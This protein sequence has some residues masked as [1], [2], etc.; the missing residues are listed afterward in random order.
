MH[1][2][3]FY[4]S[5][6]CFIYLTGLD[7]KIDQKSADSYR[8][9]HYAC[10]NGSCE[11]VTYILTKDSNQANDID[12]LD[13]NMIYLATCSGK[14][15]IVKMILKY[16]NTINQQSIDKCNSI[17]KAI[18]QK[19]FEIFKLLLARKGKSNSKNSSLIIQ[20]LRFGMYNA[21]PLLVENGED[22]DEIIKKEVEGNNKEKRIVYK[23]ALKSACEICDQ[24]KR[25]EIVKYLCSKMKKVD[26]NE[27]IKDS[28][29]VHWIC[30][31]GDPEIVRIVLDK[32]INVNR[33]DEHGHCCAAYLA[34]S[35]SNEKDIINILEQLLEHKIELN[36]KNEQC[37]SFLGEFV[38][39]YL[40]KRQTAV[41]KWLLDKGANAEVMLY[42][43][44]NSIEH[45]L[46]LHAPE[47]YTK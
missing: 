20:A 38:N 31:T 8:P 30:S 24:K 34:A 36:S 21:V 2:A 6:E 33:L 23:T 17:E 43:H 27:N 45:F 25:L 26:L 35:S 39:L 10:L 3:A 22:P 13:F 29:A 46:K 1:I 5:L 47:V 19:S 44:N 18:E 37:N 11:C 14:V 16:N 15:E 7:F 32:G 40:L 42:P 41:I 28:A 4:D 9:I 12:P